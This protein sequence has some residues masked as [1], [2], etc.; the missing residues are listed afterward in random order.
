MNNSSD[1]SAAENEARVEAHLAWQ[2]AKAAKAL[3]DLE[4]ARQRQA[5]EALEATSRQHAA[6]R[7][8][9]VAILVLFGLSLLLAPWEVSSD[10]TVSRGTMLYAPVFVAPSV[11]LGLVE[12]LV[13]IQLHAS[14]E[15]E[16]LSIW[17]LGAEWLALVGLWVA[18]GCGRPISLN[19]PSTVP[20]HVTN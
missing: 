20:P 19:K 5:M 9:K 14:L 3:A 17:T 1:K 10:G 6:A 12:G 13:G 16:R 15:W 2:D 8:W 18:M 7:R 11:V 4:A